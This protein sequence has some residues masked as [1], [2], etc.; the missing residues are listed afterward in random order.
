MAKLKS[1]LP[2]KKALIINMPEERD[3]DVHW[4]F[5]VLVIL[6]IIFLISLVFLS[7]QGSSALLSYIY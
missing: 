5:W 1:M 4:L 6:I 2:K 3:E 7:W